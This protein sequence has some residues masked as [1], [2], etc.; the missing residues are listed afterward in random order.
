[1]SGGVGC[2]HSLDPE[3]LWLWCWPVATALMRPIA[4]EP[5]YAVGEAQEMAKK[6]KK[7][8]YKR[9]GTVSFHLYKMSRIGLLRDIKE[10]K[11]F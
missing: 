5:P 9:P 7:K 4:W 11:M 10:L 8:R 2:R 3:L 1:M 6:D